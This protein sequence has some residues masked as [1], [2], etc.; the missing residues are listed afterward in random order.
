MKRLTCLVVVGTLGW[1]LSL[2][3]CAQERRPG[4][5]V[6]LFDG[7]TMNGWEIN[8]F[9]KSTKWEVVDGELRGSGGASMITCTKGPFKN[10]R[11]RAEV[12]IND[13]GNS[14]MYFRCKTTQPGFT[15]GYEAQINA[16]HGDPIKT[17]SLYTKVHLYEAA[18]KP[19]EWFTEEVECKDIKYRGQVVTA[20]KISVNGKVLFE[21]LDY[22]RQFQEGYFAFQQHDPGSKVAIRKVE[23]M[24]LP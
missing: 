21:T 16:T 14:G 24:E 9:S 5:W 8:D 12:K 20:I 17:G 2:S 11:V 4:E 18:H 1:L 15:D 7:K 6:S 22:G 10:F 19:D 23:V 3:A 13:K